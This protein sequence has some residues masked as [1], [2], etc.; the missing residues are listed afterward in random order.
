MLA[1]RSRV[2]VGPAD[3]ELPQAFGFTGNRHESERHL[4]RT[5]QQTQPRRN[6][7]S[8]R[9][10]QSAPD[11]VGAAVYGLS[12]VHLWDTALPTAAPIPAPIKPNVVITRTRQSGVSHGMG[13]T[14]LVVTPATRPINTPVRTARWHRGAFNLSSSARARTTAGATLFCKWFSGPCRSSERRLHSTIP[15]GCSR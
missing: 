9:G 4:C 11:A 10:Q 14:R 6:L 12:D 8:A 13:L 3:Y 15:T 1:S 5:R 2:S 7:C